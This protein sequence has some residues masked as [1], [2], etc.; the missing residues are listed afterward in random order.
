MKE[1]SWEDIEVRINDKV[2]EGIKSIKYIDLEVP[3]SEW[4]FTKRE[5]NEFSFV[6]TMTKIEIIITST[7]PKFHH[8]CDNYPDLMSISD[9]GVA[10]M[11]N[12]TSKSEQFVCPDCGRPKKDDKLTCF[13][14]FNEQTT[15]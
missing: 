7:D 14:C 4:K 6:H 8:L 3:R 13:N 1:Y 2:I 5:G 10:K 9:E 12:K 11:T 15:N